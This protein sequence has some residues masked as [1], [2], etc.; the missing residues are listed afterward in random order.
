MSKPSAALLMLC[1]LVSGRAGL[2]QNDD[3]AQPEPQCPAPVYRLAEV[4]V[5]PRILSKPEPGY[6]EEARRRGVS[7]RV[8]VE[9]VLCTTGKVTDVEVVRGLPAGLSE[10]AVRAARRIRFEPGTK[11][12]EAVSV[13]IRV[14]YG[15]DLH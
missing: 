14:V 15:F 12:G 2:A 10:E 3:R 5:K 4:T 11:D 1:V 8:V 13:R 9:A 7:G 6:T